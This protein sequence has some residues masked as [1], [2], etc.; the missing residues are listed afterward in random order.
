MTWSGF[1]FAVLLQSARPAG[2]ARPGEGIT[3]G[4]IVVDAL[5]SRAIQFDPARAVVMARLR[6]AYTEVG[7]LCHGQVKHPL[8]SL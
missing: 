8:F 2:R 6:M 7:I 3:L 4:L 5:G 1:A